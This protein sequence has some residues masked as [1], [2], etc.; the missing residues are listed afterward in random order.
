MVQRSVPPVGNHCTALDA[1]TLFQISF[2]LG[3]LKS[4]LV[5]LWSSGIVR[6]ELSRHVSLWQK[7]FI[8]PVARLLFL[9]PETGAQTTLHCCLQ[10][11]L[12]PLTGHYFSCCAVQKVAPHARDPVVARRLWELSTELCGTRETMELAH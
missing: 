12:E 4:V 7:I 1:V 9:D 11:G 10:E 5:L 6:T 3:T 2:V 8:E